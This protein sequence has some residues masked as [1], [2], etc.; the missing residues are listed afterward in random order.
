ML[1]FL[2]RYV[3]GIDNG[4][5]REPRVRAFAMGENAW[6]TGDRFPLAGTRPVALYLA[7][8]GGLSPHPATPPGSSPPSFSTFLSDPSQPVVDPYGAAEGAHDYR[9]L[10]L[11]KDV[12][13]FE[14]EPLEEDLRVI[15]AV[16]TE[17]FASSD[18][19]DFDLW[20]KLQD[21]A[22]D[23]TAWN[24]SSPG[25]DVLRASEREGG[26]KP[27]WLGS[28]E[29]ATF[30][31]PNLRTGNLFRK[32]H[33][34]RIVLCGSYLPYFSRNLQ[35][36][37]SEAKSSRTRTASIRIFHDAAHPARIVLPVISGEAAR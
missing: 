24:L 21:V 27:R 9:G 16:E 34:V 22:P 20:I 25:T 36:G 1:R 3:R 33:R 29:V 15:G 13:V 12:L 8:G 26:P 23:G 35:T 17:I 30:R 31:L 5:D 10:A 32:G 11:R 19:P 37:E 2:D 6:R 14:T 28:G 18:A 4:A 7:A